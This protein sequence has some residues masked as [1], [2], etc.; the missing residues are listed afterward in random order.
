MF[1]LTGQTSAGSQYP[2]IQAALSPTK[3]AGRVMVKA[4]RPSQSLAA[5]QSGA[6]TVAASHN[7]ENGGQVR[8]RNKFT[9]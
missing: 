6:T 5:R 8:I 2:H 4:R 1:Q 3:Y 7:A 9:I